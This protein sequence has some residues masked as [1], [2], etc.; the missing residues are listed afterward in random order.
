MKILHVIESLEVGGAEMLVVNLINEMPKKYQHAVCCVKKVGALSKRLPNDVKIYCLNKHEGNSLSTPF[1][2]ARIIRK[3]HYDVVHSHNWGQIIEAVIGGKIGG[4]K[5]IIHTAH[6][7]MGH[8]SGNIIKRKTRKLSEGL[9]S[10]FADKIVTVSDYLRVQ[11]ISNLSISPDNIM[12]IYNG[13][14]CKEKDRHIDNKNPT[15]TLVTVGRMVSVKNYPMLLRAFRMA[16]NKC[17]VPMRLL[18]IGDGPERNV[19]EQLK[20]ELELDDSVIFYGF[21]DDVEKFLLESDI[22]VNSS[23]YEGI[24]I[25]I[26]EAMKESIPVI[27]TSVGGN[28]EII[29]HNLSGMLVPDNDA[30]KFSEAIITLANNFEERKRIGEHGKA[31]VIEKFNIN[32]TVDSYRNLYE[33]VIC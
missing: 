23:F 5:C 16:K 32:K 10:R 2:L 1:Q 8:Y 12:I 29:T 15:L 30:E 28:K 20:D 27:A 33:S 26:L 25:A 17:S 11:I 7:V 14:I 21:R 31:L 6:G 22:F 24:S 3:N 4:A 9:I 13:V 18:F 19:L